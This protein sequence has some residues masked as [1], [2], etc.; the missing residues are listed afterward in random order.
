MGR[1]AVLQRAA[2]LLL[3]RDAGEAAL[4]Q[5]LHSAQRG[6]GPHRPHHHCVPIPK[7]APRKGRQC[8]QRLS[9][10][11]PPPPTTTSGPAPTHYR[12]LRCCTLPRQRKRP[13]TMMAILVHSASH[14]SMLPGWGGEV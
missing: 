3:Q 8:R 7:P 12:F 6:A 4:H 13:L 5:M 1:Q 9:P 14:S 11:Q 2:V 10:A